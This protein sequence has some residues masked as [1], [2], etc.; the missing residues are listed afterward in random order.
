M[1]N[2]TD[3]CLY[4]YLRIYPSV[5]M[6]VCVEFESCEEMQKIQQKCLFLTETE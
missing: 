5:H 2:S 1:I 6:C 3:M 4:Q